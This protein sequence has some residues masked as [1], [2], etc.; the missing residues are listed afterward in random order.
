MID[1]IPA[2]PCFGLASYEQSSMNI[3]FDFQLAPVIAVIAVTSVTV[4]ID[5]HHERTK[6]TKLTGQHL[7]A[8]CILKRNDSLEGPE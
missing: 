3:L 2:R 6:D 4:V 1:V 8:Q 7:G 5:C